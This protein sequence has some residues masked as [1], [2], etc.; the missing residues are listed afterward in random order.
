MRCARRVRIGVVT[1]IV[2]L[3]LGVGVAEAG[4]GVVKASNFSFKPRTMT[5][6]KGDKVKW[7]WLQGKHT[8]TFKQGSF[9]KI[10]SKSHR[11]A[12]RRF[13]KPG[14]FKYY[15]R[16]HRSLGMKGKIVVK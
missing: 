4:G 15:C 2:T 14:T 3:S 10:L 9:D 7:R 12:A 16:F 13:H 6:H 5:V 11:T 8:V 1:A